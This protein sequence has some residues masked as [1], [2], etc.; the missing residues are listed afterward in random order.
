MKNFAVYADNTVRP[1]ERVT[2]DQ[3]RRR[4]QAN[5]D[6]NTKAPCPTGVTI[7]PATAL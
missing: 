1:A 7:S 5:Q 6:R 2:G 4:P 3:N